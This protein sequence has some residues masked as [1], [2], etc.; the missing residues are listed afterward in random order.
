MIDP[1]GLVT[2]ARRTVTMA[3]LRAALAGR[4]NLPRLDLEQ[5]SNGAVQA[6][7]EMLRGLNS[8]SSVLWWVRAELDQ[9]GGIASAIDGLTSPSSAKRIRC[10]TLAGV[11]RLEDAV[12]WLGR[13]LANSDPR[14]Q[15]AAARSLGSIRGA[16]SADAL[17]RALYWR[18]GGL[19]RIVM[20]LAR[21][22]PDRY[23]ESALLAPEF[24][25][26]RYHLALA[27]GLRGRRTCVPQLLILYDV[28]V[29]SERVAVCR[30]LGW[31]GDQ[32][33]LPLLKSALEDQAWQVR[34]AAIKALT[35]I[36]DA[37]CTAAIEPLLD[38][39]YADVRTAAAVALTRFNR[40]LPGSF[41]GG[42]RGATRGARGD[43]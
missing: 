43:K 29:R 3:R 35:R 17:V 8:S 23:L 12:P 14:V 37:S 31:I 10:A 30:A 2:S 15:A 4:A 1:G 16:R 41:P 38:D 34:T 27:L 40:R 36:G 22:A 42:A 21:S 6:L 32:S 20:E 18:R 7:V 5:D 39:R 19:M 33:A 13:L 25:E 9:R 24:G 28:G 26:V 11:L